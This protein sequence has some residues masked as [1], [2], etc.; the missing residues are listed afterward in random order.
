MR[1][2]TERPLYCTAQQTED[3]CSSSFLKLIHRALKATAPD[4]G[5]PH[6]FYDI[7]K[8]LRMELS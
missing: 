2:M 1:K 4:N 8:V 3:I 6:N 5:V 7:D